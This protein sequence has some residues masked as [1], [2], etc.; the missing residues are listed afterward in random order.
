MGECV[1]ERVI[2]ASEFLREWEEDG[3][4]GRCSSGTRRVNWERLV[5]R[6]SVCAFVGIDGTNTQAC[7]YS[8]RK[9]Y[10][11]FCARRSY[12][13]VVLFIFISLPIINY[14]LNLVSNSRE[15]RYVTSTS[16]TPATTSYITCCFVV[17]VDMNTAIAQIQKVVRIHCGT[18]LLPRMPI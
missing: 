9:I 15:T 2:C 17:N 7:Y 16:A 11:Y 14:L 8:M 18:F 5:L 10:Y 4:L 1:W 12:Q 3:M 13:F 6:D